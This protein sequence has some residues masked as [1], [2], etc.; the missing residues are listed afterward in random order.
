MILMNE[1]WDR[2]GISTSVICVIHCLLTPFL[3]IFL[4]FVG[5]TL[6]HGWFHTVVVAIAVPV[7]VG[8]LW[9]GYRRHHQRAVLIW[10]ALGFAAI[11]GALGVRH[12]SGWWESGFMI[13]AGISLSAAHF[14][15]IKATRHCKV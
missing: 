12:Q 6:V 15:N 10:G 9:S 13:G 11:A 7:A 1:I 8:A 14:L 4:P 3:V 2:V 5:S